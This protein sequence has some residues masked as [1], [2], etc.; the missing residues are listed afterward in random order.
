MINLQAGNQQR[1][2]FPVKP[3][4]PYGGHFKG[5]VVHVEYGIPHITFPDQLLEWCGTEGKRRGKSSA[6]GENVVVCQQ[7][8]YGHDPAHG[9]ARH[10][11]EF[12]FRKSGIVFVDIRLKPLYD[13]VHG[14]LAAPFDTAVFRI[15]EVK[16][17]ILGQ[18][19]AAFFIFRMVIAFER[20]NDQWD[21]VFREVV[22][23][24][25]AFSVGSVAVAKKILTVK[26]IK[27][28]TAT[29]VVRHAAVRNINICFPWLISRKT[30]NCDIPFFIQSSIPL[31][32]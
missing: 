7:G 20:G 32:R 8:V 1:S 6:A 25:P 21:V 12:P 31:Y 23:N 9:T 18:A 2:H 15:R 30:G 3:S 19:T 10:K 14:E 17:R 11:R 28:G 22:Q 16:G 26:H 13:I 24:P 29:A 5:A 27:Y 4:C